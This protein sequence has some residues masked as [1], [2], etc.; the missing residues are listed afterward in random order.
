M[1]TK[2]QKDAYLTGLHKLNQQH[3][4]VGYTLLVVW[5]QDGD[6]DTYSS[7][8]CEEPDDDQETK[9][10]LAKVG[11]LL[12][13]TYNGLLASVQA[14]TGRL[15]SDHHTNGIILPDGLWCTGGT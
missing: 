1:P 3:H 6:V 5:A 10:A 11:Q 8:A 13:Y 14:F 12:Q 9:D 7:Q 2:A 15:K 4:V